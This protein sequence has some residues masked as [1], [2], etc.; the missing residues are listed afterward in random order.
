MG[1]LF[2]KQLWGAST[3]LKL[4]SIIDRNT[5]E[6]DF[7]DWITCKVFANKLSK[8]YFILRFNKPL[9]V[10]DLVKTKFVGGTDLVINPCLS[11]SKIMNL[12]IF[13]I[14]TSDDLFKINLM[15]F[16]NNKIK[17]EIQKQ[18]ISGV[19]FGNVKVI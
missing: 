18:N 16:V 1:R 13:T 11:A 10:L 7:I 17:E 4:K 12:N 5:T 14:P 19:E 8:E 9:D 3:S 6:K 15:I 2:T